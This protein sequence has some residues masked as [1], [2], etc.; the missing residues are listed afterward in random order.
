MRGLLIEPNL[1][2]AH[3]IEYLLGKN[4]VE[5]DIVYDWEGGYTS[6]FNRKYDFVIIDVYIDEPEDGFDLS[7]HIHHDSLM[8][9][10]VPIYGFTTDNFPWQ[11]EN[12]LCS[13][14]RTCFK[15]PVTHKNIDYLINDVKWLIKY[16]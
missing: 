7:R 14:M 13:G 11:F 6:L 12:A 4:G 16:E 3:A 10:R 15:A 8:N 1:S 9:P 5:V 2:C